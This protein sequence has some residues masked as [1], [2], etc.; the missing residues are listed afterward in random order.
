MNAATARAALAGFWA[1]LGE[2]PSDIEHVAPVPVPLPAR[3]PVAALAWAGVQAASLALARAAG[4]EEV[5]LD[6]A[7]IAAAYRSERH[8]RIDGRSPA[9]WSP[10]SGFWRTADGWVRTHGN[11]PAHTAA[12]LRGLELSGPSA[13]AVAARL[14]TLP[15]D[16]A[17][18]A[19]AAQGGLCVPVREERSSVDAALR[20][21]PVVRLERIGSGP[22]LPLPSPTA[23][24]PLSGVRVLDLTRVIAG[25][26]CTRTL[27]L[28]GADVLR[29]DPPQ[30]PEF[31]WQHLDTGHGKRSALLDLLGERDRFGA[32][33]ADADVVVLGYRPAGLARLGLSPA[34]LIAAHPHLVVAQLSAW[35]TPERRGFDSLV[36]AA[37]GIAWIES[38]SGEAP[39]AL[40]AQAL[41]H[42]A[43]YLLAAAVATA[44][45]RR[46]VEGGGWIAETSLR[47]VAAELLTLPRDPEHSGDAPPEEPATQLFDVAG[48]SVR[49]A[50]PAVAWAGGAEGYAPPRPWGRDQAVWR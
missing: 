4:A 3:L 15:G 2:E 8:L 25:P 32:L 13:D 45:H 22:V 29:I 41:D 30:L 10:L 18:A 33:L 14:Q 11:Y 31:G 21:D 42:T 49:T 26:V 27:A 34:A 24:A 48:S 39:G 28:A 50:R 6:G 7:R 44:L 9:A 1:A 23:A 43:G 20:L 12:L 19:V 37:S 36:Q 47:R 40:P 16:V 38:P 5:R 46:A 17:C 35:G